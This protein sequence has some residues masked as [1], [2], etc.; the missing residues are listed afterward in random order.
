MFSPCVSQMMMIRSLCKCK[1]RLNRF[2]LLK[3]C[4]NEKE[5][6]LLNFI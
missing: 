1:W 5:I 6:K 3:N 4:V 2:K